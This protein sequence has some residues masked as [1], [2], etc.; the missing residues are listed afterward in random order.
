MTS[1]VFAYLASYSTPAFRNVLALIPAD[2]LDVQT[3]DGR[4]T[5]REVLGHLAD[6]ERLTLE[7]VKLAVAESGSSI[8]VPDAM[9]MARDHA[10]STQDPAVQ[11]ARFAEMRT[12][13]CRYV[14]GLTD[15]EMQRFVLCPH[16]GK[17]TVIDQLAF[18]LGHDVFHLDQLTGVVP[19]PT[20]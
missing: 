14:E 9:Q 4:F 3:G 19:V 16:R 7:W 15:E 10:Y 18:A 5:V 8:E 6:N 2:R 12:E 11:L 17:V 20:A 13:L 1:R